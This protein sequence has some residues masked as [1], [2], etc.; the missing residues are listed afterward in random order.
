[1]LS[2]FIKPSEGEGEREGVDLISRP[3]NDPVMRRTAVV[4]QS[5]IQQVQE[6]KY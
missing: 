4:F 1:M 3:H 6:V 2:N 5:L